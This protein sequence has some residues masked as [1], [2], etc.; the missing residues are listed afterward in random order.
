MILLVKYKLLIF[1]RFNLVI[2]LIYDIVAV[3]K[4]AYD[5][6]TSFF[7]MHKKIIFN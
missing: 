3:Q 7:L 1:I 6:D 4:K 2:C 5:S